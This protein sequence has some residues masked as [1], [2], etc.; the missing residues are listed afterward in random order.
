MLTLII[1][2]FALAVCGRVLGF[3]FKGAFNIMMFFLFVVLLPVILVA[4]IFGGLIAM[5]WPV[6]V[7]AGIIF[8]VK[9]C[10]RCA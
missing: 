1:M 3:V 8:I 9:R 6:L 4:V 10:V 2:F 7:I 5:A